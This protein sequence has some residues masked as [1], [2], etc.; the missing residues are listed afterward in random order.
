[1]VD[2]TGTTGIV[3]SLNPFT[4]YNCSIFAFTVLPGP[5][6][7]PPIKVTTDQSGITISKLFSKCI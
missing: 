1:M 7:D 6:S 4:E 5:A 2:S 3:G